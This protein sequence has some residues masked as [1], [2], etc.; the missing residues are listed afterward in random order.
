MLFLVGRT[1]GASTITA[2]LAC[3]TSWCQLIGEV[4]DCQAAYAHAPV[5][6]CIAYGRDNRGVQCVDGSRLR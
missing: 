3:T 1:H 2:A 5:A 6:M 4:F